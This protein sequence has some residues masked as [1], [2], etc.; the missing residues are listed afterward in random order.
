MRS[1]PNSYRTSVLFVV[2]VALSIWTAATATAQSVTPTA[3]EGAAEDVNRI[4]LRINNEIVTLHD[5]EQRRAGDIARILADSRLSPSDRQEL[6]EKA[7]RE[8]MSNLFGEM[9]LVSYADQH[10]IRIGERD[11]DEA[12]QQMMEQRDISSR[13]EL[14][15]A[16]AASNMTY[17]E[18]RTS[19]TRELIWNQVIG[20]EVRS[21][22]DIGDEEVRAYYRNNPESFQEQEKR[23]LQEVIVLESSGLADAELQRLA[24]EISGRLAAGEDLATVADAYGEQESVTDVID[25]GW[26]NADEIGEDLSEVAWSLESGAYSSPIAARGGYHILHVVEVQE[27]KMMQFQEVEERI[28]GYLRSQEFNREL[29]SFMAEIEQQAYV[30]ENLPP[31]AVGYQRLAEGLEAEDELEAFRAPLVPKPD[32]PEGQEDGAI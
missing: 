14:E 25:L 19:V 24:Q 1:K 4:V 23:W 16:L 28:L 22:I 30:R 21:R 5:Y 20:R 10:G 6:I 17:D 15:E 11:V 27:A 31:E 18:L 13:R 2:L 7:G 3:A 32:V 9:L 12:V 26:L 8:A 29:R